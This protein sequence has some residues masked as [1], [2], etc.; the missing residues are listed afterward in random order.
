MFLFSCLPYLCHLALFSGPFPQLLLFFISLSHIFNFQELFL[1]LLSFCSYFNILFLFHGCTFYLSKGL[2]FFFFNE[3]LSLQ[4]LSSFSFWFSL[5]FRL[6]LSSDVRW[7]FIFSAYLL[8]WSWKAKKPWAYRWGL[9]TRSFSV[10]WS[11]LAVIPWIVIFLG[12]S[13]K[14]S[15]FPEKDL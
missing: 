6:V 8:I 11:A 14:R 15:D 5:S 3:L 10:K 13:P 12:I 4:S 9:S 7:F 2:I 1:V